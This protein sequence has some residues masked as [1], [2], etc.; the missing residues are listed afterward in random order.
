M[1]KGLAALAVG[2]V[3]TLLGAAPAAADTGELKLTVAG[4]GADGV[5]VRATHADGRQ[6]ETL[7]RLTLNATGPDGQRVGPVQLE[8]SAEGQG[9]YSIGSI[10]SPGRWRVTV[11]TPAPDG[12]EA[13]AQVEARAP[14]SPPAPE[15]VAAQPDAAGRGAGVGWWP[16][17]AG[18][19]VLV[20]AV[21]A[22]AM[23]SSRRRPD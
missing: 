18:G 20:A 19:L 7:V 22:V 11:S 17:A 13:S 16:V 15:P 14:G 9:F 3:L 1:W 10:L 21:I 4:D 8:P 6:L 5:T 23:L 2:L 12:S